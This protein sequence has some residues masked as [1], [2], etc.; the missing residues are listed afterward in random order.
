MVP[1]SSSAKTDLYALR[2]CVT[3][4]YYECICRVT[5]STTD[6]IVISISNCYLVNFPTSEAFLNPD[7]SYNMRTC[8]V[9]LFTRYNY[10]NFSEHRCYKSFNFPIFDPHPRSNPLLMSCQSYSMR[11]GDFQRA[12][13]V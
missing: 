4:I 5:R 1:V 3:A 7:C 2:I 13:V 12:A 10:S 6:V 11:P 8:G 9:L